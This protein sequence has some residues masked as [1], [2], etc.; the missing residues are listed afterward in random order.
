MLTT[1]KAV[2]GC[3]F[4]LPLLV[5]GALASNVNA[6]MVVPVDWLN[7]SNNIITD[8]SSSNVYEYL[9][10]HS[11]AS[12]TTG[13]YRVRLASG[14]LNND[15]LLLG[16]VEGTVT[17]P[18]SQAWQLNFYVV[19]DESSDAAVASEYVEL[20]LNRQLISTVYNSAP[21]VATHISFDFF[22]DSF[23]YLFNFSSP[24]SVNTDHL[25]VEVGT[26]SAVPLPPSGV[27][28]LFALP[29]VFWGTRRQKV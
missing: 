20:N 1:G 4:L 19:T 21:E 2:L 24:S 5:V 17:L 26:V 29:L 11:A 15:G 14:N 13:I 9:S 16:Y 6:A 25:I 7:D 10:D 27:L 23:T 3:K 22:G 8:L 28:S 18:S 12:P